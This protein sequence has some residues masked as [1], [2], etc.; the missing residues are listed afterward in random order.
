MRK[1]VRIGDLL[2]GDGEP[3]MIIAEIG[4]NHT[5]SLEIAW[6]LIDEA[7]DAGCNAVKFQKRTVEVVYS[8]DELARPRESPFGTTNGDLKRALEFGQREYEGIDRYCKAKKIM[9]S[10]SCWDPGSVEFVER[11]DPPFYKIASACL[12]DH[13]L[14]RRHRVTGRPIVLSTGMST[15]DQIRH[16]VDVLGG[17]DALVILH[18]TS[19]YP[20]R[21][22][23]LNLR[24]IQSLREEFDCPIGYSGHEVGLATTVAAVMVGAC[25]V[26]R[27]ITLDRSLWGSD[28]AA[29]VES[30]GFKR[31][32]RDIRV[33]ELAMGD[34][35][36]KVY[37]SELPIM[38]KLRRVG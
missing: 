15:M 10:A 31:L 29:S 17:T 16:A 26:E 3:C 35:I 12:T 22:E 14:L 38:A 1:K 8:P 20:S 18:C 28:Q 37:D 6:R 27:H 7:V 21:P 25:M 34:G 32:V 36:K 33:C 23:E 24:M 9:W 2:V 5:G 4:I 13:D 11:F 30:Q 19:T